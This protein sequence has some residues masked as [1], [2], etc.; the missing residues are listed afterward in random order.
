MAI[1]IAIKHSTPQPRMPFVPSFLLDSS[2]FGA[3]IRLTSSLDTI[4]FSPVRE[5]THFFALHVLE[6]EAWFVRDRV[7]EFPE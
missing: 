1:S 4:F 5:V 6:L 3:K 2:D 7:L